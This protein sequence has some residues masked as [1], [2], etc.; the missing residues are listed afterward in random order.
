MTSNNDSRGHVALGDLFNEDTYD[1]VLF[2]DDEP[3][4]GPVDIVGMTWREITAARM[5]G[6]IGPVI[7]AYADT[8]GVPTADD[9]T[10]SAN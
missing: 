6:R 7:S 1:D 9:D 3:P 8:D 5:A 10:T 2:G 4:F